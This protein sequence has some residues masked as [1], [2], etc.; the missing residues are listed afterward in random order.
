MYFT[1]V[2]IIYKIYYLINIY[3]LLALF[4]LYLV[5]E[6][7]TF[8]YF[9]I[10]SSN[11]FCFII[12]FN[13]FIIFSLLSFFKSINL[14][15]IHKIWVFFWDLSPPFNFLYDIFII[16]NYLFILWEHSP[17]LN[18][19]GHFSTYKFLWE[20]SPPFIFFSYLFLLK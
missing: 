16:E 11:F 9:D 8:K 14:Q 20:H 5:G 3:Y 17:L 13:F 4:H 10:I 7:T 1:L 12:Y 6:F 18:F 19:S 15:I 2:F